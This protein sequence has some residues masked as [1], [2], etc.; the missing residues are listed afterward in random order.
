MK[1]TILAKRYA[2]ALFAVSREEGR[3]KE[4]SLSLNQLGLMCAQVPVVMDGLT[5]PLYPQEIRAGVMTTLLGM[6]ESDQFLKNFCNL[7]VQKKRAG[8]LP[9]IASEYQAIVDADENVTRGTVISATELSNELLDK[10]QT[11]LEKIT[12][13]KVILTAQVDASILGG[14]VAK[15]GDLIM[16]GSIRTQLTGLNKS[17]IGSV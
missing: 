11:A 3:S 5:N 15:V 9:E 4:Y 2:K 17:I 12:G 10:V 7:L 14:I 16:D 6:V 13:K 8:I 1:Q